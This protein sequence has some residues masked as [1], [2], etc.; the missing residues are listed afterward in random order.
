[1]EQTTFPI[2]QNLSLEVMLQW[3]CKKE[4]G[5]ARPFTVPLGAERKERRDD[6]KAE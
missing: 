1:M 2:S 3:F 5:H 4:M 6:P